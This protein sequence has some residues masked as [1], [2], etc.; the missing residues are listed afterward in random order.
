[1]VETLVP[2]WRKEA[3]AHKRAMPLQR[4]IG[5]GMDYADA[6]D[7]YREV[8]TGT[9]WADAAAGLGASAREHAERKLAAGHIASARDY[10]HRA[11]AC[12]RFG[13]VPLIDSDPRKLDMYEKLIDCFAQAGEL[14]EPR[15]QHVE[16]P[17]KGGKLC[18]WLLRPPGDEV[19]PVVIQFG[20]F[21][22]WR[23]EY[24]ANAQYLLQRGIA[25]FLVD[26]PGQGETRLFHHLYLDAD[27]ASAFSAFVDSVHANPRLGSTVG[28]WGNSLGGYIAAL[29]A[30]SEPRIAACCVNGGTDR[31]A[32]IL[33]RYPRFITKIQLLLGIEDAAEAHA[34]IE[35]LRLG[36]EVLAS[37]RCPLHVV[38]G[39]PDRIF[40][41]ESAR[42]VYRLAAAPDKLLSEFPDG[43]HCIYNRSHER[44][45]LVADWFAE[46]LGVAP[47][48]T[49]E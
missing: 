42:S 37:L 14:T 30:A 12:Y 18:G 1:V 4:L 22:G 19:P 2:A 5:N 46:R 27:V 23:E 13:Q 17:W 15:F 34:K 7:L 6:V 33:D 21:D 31:P 40:L 44:N 47:G 10:F 20:G 38:H 8:D 48:I 25:V 49:N 16:I 24:F 26:G 9:H 41:I 45:C 28:I 43:D 35:S 36:P 3:E 29:V 11:S 39:T 32:E